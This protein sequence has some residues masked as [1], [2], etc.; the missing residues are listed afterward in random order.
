MEFL[1]SA[2]AFRVCFLLSASDGTRR[3]YWNDVR[4]WIGFSDQHG[5]APSRPDVL[6][7]VAWVEAMKSE[8]T[9]TGRPA[10]SK[11]RARR[12]AALCSVFRELVRQG[13]APSNPFSPDTGPRREKAHAER[14]TQ[15]I[16]AKTV[17]A[18]S[19]LGAFFHQWVIMRR[20]YRCSGKQSN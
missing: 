2:A 13:R 18:M 14:P 7:V 6:E 17:A 3:A 12:M 4:H 8:P 15:A 5:V 19:I 20:A 11:T 16:S 1:T 9:R 10:S